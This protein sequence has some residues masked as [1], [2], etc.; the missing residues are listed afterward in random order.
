M[1]SASQKAS[2]R[3]YS[4]IQVCELVLEIKPRAGREIG[5]AKPKVMMETDQK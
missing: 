2:Y 5:T 4:N 1:G 3:S